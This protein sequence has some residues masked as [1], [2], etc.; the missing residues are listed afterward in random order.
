MAQT[1]SGADMALFI[2]MDKVLVGETEQGEPIVEEK[3]K[4]FERA[5]K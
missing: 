5:T 1:P 3:K 4:F 2:G